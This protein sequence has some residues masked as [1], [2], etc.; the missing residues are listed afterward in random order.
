MRNLPLVA[1]VV[2]IGGVTAAAGQDPGQG[3]SPP[4]RAELAWVTEFAAT[5]YSGFESKTAGDRLDG[6]R[7]LV[8]QLETEAALAETEAECD[9]LLRR[10]AGFFQDGHLS[11]GRRGPATGDAVA[12]TASPPTDGEIRARFA[13]WPSRNL[14]ETEGRAALDALGGRRDPVEGIWESGDAAYRGIVVRNDEAPGRYIM[15]ILR[16]DSVW[17]LPGQVKAIFEGSGADAYDI[18]FFMRDHS[19]QAWTGSVD[20]NV[21]VMGQGSTWFRVYPAL[22]DDVARDAY[23]DSHNRRFA[24]RG[25]APGTVVLHLPSFDD[26]VRMD[27]LFAAE[28]DRIRD[29]ERLLIDLRG[30]GGGSDYNFRA[31]VPLL[32]TDPIRIVSNEVLATPANI[33]ANAALA[34]DTTIPA[35]IR[36]QLSRQVE[37]MKASEGGWLPFPDRTHELSEVLERPARVAVLVDGRCASSCEQFL[38]MAR[39]SRKVTIYGEPTAGILDFGNVR[40]ATMP[41]GTLRLFYPTTRSKRLPHAPVDGIGVLPDV[42]VPDGHADP[43]AWVLDRLDDPGA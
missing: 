26:P 39:Q 2:L 38:L 41:S 16:A 36:E 9:V 20:R 14:T 1:A 31:L 32:Y 15:S 7:D 12:A 30:N 22:P 5:N 17:W 34:A 33:A 4:C 27:S 25:E 18:R 28:A 10:W 43:V 13:D 29:A 6:Y 3:V 21:L 8:R 19:E 37:D 40:S 35:G 23:L 24:A 11:L 42:L